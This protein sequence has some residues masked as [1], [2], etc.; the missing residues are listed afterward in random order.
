VTKVYTTEEIEALLAG[1]SN[2]GEWEFHYHGENSLGYNVDGLLDGIR[3]QFDRH[4]DAEFIAATPAIIRQL[5]QRV[6]EL[7]NQ[8]CP[9]CGCSYL[10]TE[11]GT[12]QCRYC[13]TEWQSL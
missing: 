10:E 12:N 4:E 2:S 8:F 11:A 3:Y 5:L 1:L 7:D 9:S 6:R 13:G